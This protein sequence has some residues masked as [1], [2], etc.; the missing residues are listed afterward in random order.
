M[1]WEASWYMADLGGPSQGV[2]NQIANTVADIEQLTNA[3]L[4]GLRL[5]QPH[6]PRAITLHATNSMFEEYSE[7]ADQRVRST[8]AMKR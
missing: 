7:A 5:Y 2:R 3:V 4:V 1:T 8:E 6:G